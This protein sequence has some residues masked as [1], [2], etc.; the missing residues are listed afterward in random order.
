MA[1]I[2][3]ERIPAKSPIIFYPVLFAIYPVL[4]IYSGNLAII[5]FVMTLRPMAVTLGA[6]LLIWVFLGL[7][8][9]SVGRGAIASTVIVASTFIFTQLQRL[10]YTLLY[11]QDHDFLVWIVFTVVLVTLA[12]WKF[13]WHKLANFLSIALL[14]T[15]VAQIVFGLI[16]SASIRPQ[17]QVAL[18]HADK[19]NVNRPDIFYVIL[20]GYGRSDALKRA[21]NY[22]ND[23]FIKGLESRGFYVAK[24][25]RANYCQTELSVGSSLNLNYIQSL[26]TK[27]TIKEHDR[28]PLGEIINHNAAAKYLRGQGYTFA[29][30]TTG[31][32]PLQF[33]SADVNMQ[34]FS[35]MSL[36]E[37]ALLQLTPLVKDENAK[38]TYVTKRRESLLGAFESFN[39]LKVKSIKPRFVVVHILA[40]HPPFVFGPN[41][42]ELPHKGPPGFWDGS[43]YLDHVSDTKDYR[44]GYVGQAEYIGMK[45]LESI[46]AVMSTSGEKPVVI[47]QGDHGSKLRLD[48]NSLAKTDVNECFP[49]L[50]AYHVPDSVRASLYPGITPVNS[51]RVLFNGLFGDDF[52]LLP[53]KSWYS[54][55]PLPYDFTEV[56]DQIAT[57]D[58]I[59]N[60]PLSK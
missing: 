18:G 28:M 14:A 40:P 11:T 49:N 16:H 30:V 47:I 20:D 46:D 55:F 36:L 60:V 22:D 48:Q 26:L 17:E 43:D 8:F 42:E 37:T 4:S 12:A 32:P 54:T 56:T 24:D 23:S 19:K 5:P 27:V 1:E 50:N 52:P 29:A 34:S 33:N 3:V 38:K 53:D 10:T 59:L 31:F 44:N 13:S 35:G 7:L 2:E 9:R 58:R 6:V 51:F 39:M 45:M 25:A 41:G 21:M 15:T 57:H